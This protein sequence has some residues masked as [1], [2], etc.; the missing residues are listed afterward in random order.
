MFHSATLVPRFSQIIRRDRMMSVVGSRAVSTRGMLIHGSL[1]ARDIEA[2]VTSPGLNAIGVRMSMAPDHKS[3]LRFILNRRATLRTNTAGVADGWPVA[4]AAGE[5]M[6][7]AACTPAKYTAFKRAF[8]RISD[9]QTTMG[10]ATPT[11]V[12]LRDGCNAANRCGNGL[13]N[14]VVIAGM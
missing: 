8:H 14:G 5:S 3:V 7:S 13:N 10:H 11:R 12:Y 1:R 6:F 2:R 9:V 4:L